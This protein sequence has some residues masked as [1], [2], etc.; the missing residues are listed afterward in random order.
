MSLDNFLIKRARI[1]GRRHQRISL[2]DKMMFFQ[3]LASLI[4]AGVPL[5][6]AVELT[7]E[8]AESERLRRV[9]LEI[10]GRVAAG[11]PLHA[12][13]AAHRNVFADHWIALI[14]TGEATGQMEHVLNDLNAQIR[15][16]QETRRKVGGALT[17][18]FILLVVAVLVMVI[19]L[20]FVVPV[21]S[22]M[23]AEM[24]ADL[25]GVTQCVVSASD[26]VVSWGIYLLAGLALGL[27]LLRRYWRSERGRRRLYALLLALPLSG[28][29][30]VSAAM[31][32]FASNLALLLK[33]GV[34]LLDALAAMAGVFRT[35]PPYQ[36]AIL[37]AQ[38]RVA[39]GRPLADSLDDC[40]LFTTMIINTIRI[41]E[42]SAQLPF[43][44]AQ[45]APYYREKMNQFLSRFTK[46][47]EPSIIIVM[48]FT[49][50]V[51]MLAIYL[52]MF[53]LSGKVH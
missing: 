29:L 35:Q 19:M 50:A 13:L 40:G 31:Y 52:P 39:A 20:W 27:F 43:V 22:G 30:A 48:G 23:F 41:G 21:F 49:M 25:P 18:P 1:S 34:P 36:D 32:R 24:G 46:L 10:A 4:T 53:E 11:V 8:Q 14:A 16:A 2:D 42:E 6:Q 44:L 17:Y 47:L 9:L 26:F 28:E 15:E 51:I 45:M 37:V 5:L 7:S 33:S 12:A 38:R 3:Q